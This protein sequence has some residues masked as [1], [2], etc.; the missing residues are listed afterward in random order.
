MKLESD[1]LDF[2]I[3]IQE[4]KRL[5]GLDSI[6]SITKEIVISKAQKAIPNQKIDW[7]FIL[8]ITSG[9]IAVIFAI[10]KGIGVI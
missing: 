10:L 8:K 6:N 3:E 4:R 5:L 2:G 1:L 9:V 7:P